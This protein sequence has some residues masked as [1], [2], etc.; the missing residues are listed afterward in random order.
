[1]RMICG[2]LLSAVLSAA[3]AA[4]VPFERI[5]NADKEPGNWLTYSRDLLGHRFSPLK[6]ITAGER[7]QLESEVGVSVS[8]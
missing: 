7:R 2:V 1:M 6:E 4:Q 8:E 3:A 5:A